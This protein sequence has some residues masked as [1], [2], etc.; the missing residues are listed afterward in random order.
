MGGEK[1]GRM[2][3]RE[4]EREKGGRK[5]GELDGEQVRGR[6]KEKEGEERGGGGWRGGERERRR[7]G[8][9]REWGGK[10][11]RLTNRLTPK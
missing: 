4:R 3:L 8:T 6:E 10:K 9:E 1:E 5:R 11:D 2:G 7:E